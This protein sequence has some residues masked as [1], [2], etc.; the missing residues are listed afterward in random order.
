MCIIKL[1]Q[2]IFLCYTDIGSCASD[3]VHSGKQLCYFH[4]GP[5]F[6][7][8]NS[9]RKKFTSLKKIFSLCEKTPVLKAVVMLGSR[10]EVKKVIPLC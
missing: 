6:E 3:S 9:K 4:F 5:S 2:Y 8:D 1:H 10:M 7:W